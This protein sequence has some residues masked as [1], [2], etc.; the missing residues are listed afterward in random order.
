MKKQEDEDKAVEEWMGYA[1]ALN[2]SGGYNYWTNQQVPKV[3]YRYIRLQVKKEEG[4]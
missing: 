3:E 1:N 4:S 2:V